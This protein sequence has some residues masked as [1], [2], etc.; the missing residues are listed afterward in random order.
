MSY[1]RA[2][3]RCWAEI[4]R[5]AAL[6]VRSAAE[7]GMPAAQLRLGRMLLE[8][9]G[10]PR[11]EREAFAWFTRAAGQ[12]EAD[13]MNMLGRCH[14]NGWGVPADPAARRRAATAPS[15]DAGHDW[16]EYNLGNLLLEGRGIAP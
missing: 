8:G 12:G 4:R 1:P 14:E 16:G 6:W 11:D 10:T 9:R 15:A 2:A 3:A 7:H 5:D 13:A